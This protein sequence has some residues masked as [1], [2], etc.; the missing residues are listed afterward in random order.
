VFEVPADKGYV[1]GD[2]TIN[3]APIEFGA[4]IADFVSIKLV[5]LA[6]RIGKST[7]QAKTRC[8]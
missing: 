3:G 6:C 1:V 5:G 4:Q 7:V 8:A 2:I